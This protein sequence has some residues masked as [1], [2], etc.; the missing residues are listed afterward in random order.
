MKVSRADSMLL[1]V[2]YAD[3]FSWPLTRE[4]LMRWAILHS[5]KH[6]PQKKYFFAPKKQYLVKLRN[7]KESFAK[8]KW[9]IAR[10][11]GEWLRYIPSLTLVGVTGGLSR[12]NVSREDDIDF[13]CLAAPGT[14]WITRMLATSMMGLLGL[15]RRPGDSDVKNKICLNMFMSEDALNVQKQE[16]DLF[17]AYE[18]L[19]M[20]PLW[21]RNGIYKRFLISNKWVSRFLPNAWKKRVR[22]TQHTVGRKKII[23]LFTFLEPLARCLQL[24]YMRNR[25]TSEVIRPGLLRFH[26]RDARVWVREAFAERLSRYN[27]PL[28]KIFYDR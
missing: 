15:R 17:T 13:F 10:R 8:E 22:S 2:L 28:D 24:W 9:R 4:E 21:E 7:Q 12:N 27:L 3:I 1:T 19:Q 14:I 23:F 18:V 11:S 20:Q 25:R 26:P 5:P 6:I 16:Q